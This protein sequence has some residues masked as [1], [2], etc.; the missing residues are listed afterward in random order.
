MRPSPETHT[1]LWITPL[2]QHRTTEDQG[3]SPHYETIRRVLSKSPHPD[4]WE[5]EIETVIEAFSEPGGDI[6]WRRVVVRSGS[7]C[8]RQVVHA[9]F[10]LPDGSSTTALL[11]HD[12]ILCWAAFQER[13]GR[14]L[15][16]VLASPTL[17][18]I[19]D[20]YPHDEGKGAGL[21]VEGHCIPLP[22]E[23]RCIHPVGDGRGILLQRMDSMEDRLIF[24][25]HSRTWTMNSAT[26][27]D[28]DG[29]FLKAPP[30]PTGRG[31][32]MT[33][34]NP[35]GVAMN[36][37]TNASGNP[38]PSFFSLSHPLDDVLP[39]SL[40]SNEKNDHPRVVSDVFEKVLFAGVLSWANP[41][42]S[43]IDRREYSQPICV[44]Y[45]TLR[46]R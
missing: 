25:L 15:L 33:R 1:P 41:S 14:K 20:A 11:P 21:G 28:D 9:S 19:W 3:D 2:I 17:L 23:A 29:F 35:L 6:L 44:T 43:G 46:Q 27:D 34:G 24:D 31:N 38:V 5:T 40:L 42:E 13:P 26:E 16:C 8:P 45:H 22:F 7:S 4:H 36:M 39:V 10:K 32:E 30:R 18:C 37:P 12:S